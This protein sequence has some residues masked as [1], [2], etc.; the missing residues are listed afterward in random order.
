MPTKVWNDTLPSGHKP[1]RRKN[2][3]PRKVV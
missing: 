1:W 3:E 2:R